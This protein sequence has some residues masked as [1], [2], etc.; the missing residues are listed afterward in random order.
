MNHVQLYLR[1]DE[2]SFILPLQTELLFDAINMKWLF[3]CR[4]IDRMHK[5]NSGDLDILFFLYSFYKGK[6][7][8]CIKLNDWFPFPII[9]RAKKINGEKKPLDICVTHSLFAVHNPNSNNNST[10]MIFFLFLNKVNLNADSF[11]SPQFY[12]NFKCVSRFICFIL[13]AKY[14]NQLFFFFLLYYYYEK[15][16]RMATSTKMFGWLGC[17]SSKL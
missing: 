12:C 7:G 9:W 4:I 16:E 17:S 13:H 15:P 2:D 10:A 1:F 5:Y 6:H 14:Q 8:I 11:L 3:V